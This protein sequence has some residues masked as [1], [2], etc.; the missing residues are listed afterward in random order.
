M[1]L[2]I[3]P[4]QLG[5]VGPVNLKMLIKYSGNELVSTGT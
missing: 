1:E 4:G 2:V 5:N 3:D